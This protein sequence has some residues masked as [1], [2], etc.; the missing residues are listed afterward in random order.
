MGAQQQDAALCAYLYIHIR[1]KYIHICVDIDMCSQPFDGSTTDIA[2]PCVYTYS[3][4][5]SLRE[6]QPIGHRHE[7]EVLATTLL[8]DCWRLKNRSPKLP[9][10]EPEVLDT[11]SEPVGSGGL[12][13][14]LRA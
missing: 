2:V 6:K 14:V 4:F 10:R 7:A 9:K 13:P 11:I 3:C 8:Q 12:F 1:E 5:H